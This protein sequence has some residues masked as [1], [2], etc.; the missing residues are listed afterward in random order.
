[1][2]SAPDSAI[3][4]KESN[5]GERT[6]IQPL[7]IF[8]LALVS[9]PLPFRISRFQGAFIVLQREFLYQNV[10]NLTARSSRE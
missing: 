5:L 4:S 9:G 1:V 7:S 3:A 10:L 2:R 8:G 6:K